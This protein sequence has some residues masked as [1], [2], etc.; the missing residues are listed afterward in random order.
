MAAIDGLAGTTL[1]DHPV[2]STA[3]PFPV[4]AS[5][6]AVAARPGWL[7][8]A[9]EGVTFI[10][11]IEA[12]RLL[13]VGS[14][15]G[16]ATLLTRTIPRPYLVNLAP[17]MV[18]VANWRP[19]WHAFYKRDADGM[20]RKMP[21]I[22]HGTPQGVLVADL[23]EL[24]RAYGRPLPPGVLAMAKP[25]PEGVP[26]QLQTTDATIATAMAKCAG[27]LQERA[28]TAPPHDPGDA[29]GGS[30]GFPEGHQ[31]HARPARQPDQ[32]PVHQRPADRDGAA[33]PAE[34]SHTQRPHG[35]DLRASGQ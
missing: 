27:P 21:V 22:G 23:T 5:A 9:G 11:I 6:A 24:E 8:V 18:M 29:H 35:L 25:R 10:D 16:L 31:L 13:R 15:V 2:L 14:L 3:T 12:I 1:A 7:P 17:D 19:G 20:W 4:V 34:A 30:P 26:K 28:G 32:T 33:V